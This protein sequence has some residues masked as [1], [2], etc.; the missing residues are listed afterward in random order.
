VGGTL[1]DLGFTVT[2][3]GN[4]EPGGG[5]TGIR[6]S[7]DRAAAAQ[8]LAAAVPSA[9]GT[10]DPAP[11]VLQLVLGAGSTT[12]SAPRGSDGHRRAS[13]ARHVRLTAREGSPG[14]HRGL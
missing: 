5:T 4:A 3:V 11:R 8:V 2:G 1:G 6:F 10:P 14:V 13:G 12:C 7:P 9:V